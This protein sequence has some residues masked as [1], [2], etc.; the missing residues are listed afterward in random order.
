MRY[1]KK[2]RTP[3]SIINFI[4]TIEIEIKLGLTIWNKNKAV[5][6][7]PTINIKE[8]LFKDNRGE[9]LFLSMVLFMHIPTIGWLLMIQ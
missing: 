5:I 3:K 1:I 9:F 2:I 7:I 4:V 6:F 8:A